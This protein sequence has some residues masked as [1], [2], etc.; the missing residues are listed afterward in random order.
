MNINI[1]NQDDLLAYLR[2]KGQIEAT[3]I[4]L[5]QQLTGGVS[6]RTVLVTRASGEAW[7][8]KQALPKLRV[9]TDW[10]SD[11]ARIHREALGLRW[12]RELTPVGAIPALCFE[13]HEAHLIGMAAVAQPHVNWK[14]VLLSGGLDLTHI[15]KFAQMLAA[16]HSNS[17][18]RR[19][20]IAPEFANRTFFE[21]LRL[22]PYYGYT[23]EQLPAAAAFLGDLI[24]ETRRRTLTLVHGDYSPKNVLIR[25]EQLV[26]LDHE[27]IHWGDQAF[28]LGFSL[29]HLL[30]KA[31]YLVNQRTAFADA[32][33]RY[34]RSYHQTVLAG[35][36][37]APV[38]CDNLERFTI[39]H[40]LACLLARAYGRSPLE[41]LSHDQR[42]KQVEVVLTAFHAQ[43][44]SVEALIL[45][46]VNG[47]QAENRLIHLT[48]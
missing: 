30:S 46:F 22:E 5:I 11:P 6:N 4:P 43:P 28:D 27:V 9:A 41:Y 24:D 8:L 36:Q 12:L 48:E 2:S 7:V 16:I 47:L 20:I 44:V 33:L 1:G 37:A 39:R 38:W 23:A 13:D 14:Q 3:E 25:N 40:T 18:Q 31:H 15:D 19:A 42:K 21:S 29:T 26:L 35:A 32:A 10:F 17:W 34:W 45:L